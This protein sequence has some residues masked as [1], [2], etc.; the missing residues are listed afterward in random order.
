MTRSASPRFWLARIRP[1]VV[2]VTATA[3]VALAA[4]SSTV[5]ST[6]GGSA[7]SSAQASTPL[8]NAAA[9]QLDDAIGQAMTKVSIPGAIVGIWGPAGNY[10]RTFGVADKATRA[11]M[12]TDMYIRIGSVTKTFTITAL[13]QLVDQGKLAL[14]DPISKYM[15]G[16]PSG[17]QIT[18][19][20]LAQ[21]RSGLITFD[22]VAQFSDPYIADPHK[23]FTPA[24]LL[25]YALDKPLQFPPGTQY[26]YSNTN[27]VLLGLVVEKQSGQTLQ[28]Y[29]SEHI[30]A[31]LKLSHTSFSTTPAFP[32]PH[33][34]GYTT[35]HGAAQISTDWNFSWAWA[36]GNMI[37]TL[38]DMRIWARALATGALL[39]PETQRQRLDTS[40]PMSPKQTAFY[41]LGLINAAGWI[42]HAGVIFGYE[43]MAFY[44]PQTQTT[45]VFFINTDV[46]QEASAALAHAITSVI[47]PDHVIR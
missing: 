11:P 23:S 37:S 13:L 7:T 41:G 27:T 42:G 10:V 12:S 5:P 31:P 15:S 39:K 36:A 17:D 2:A 20:E 38:D 32:D 6:S 3:M 28:D 46:P 8:A 22:D 40:V 19:R 4:C 1:V 16:V 35:L 9:T 45:L 26:Q 34:Q 29:I 30:L 14:D 25:G 24:Q 47:C 43:T 44:L 21:M 18:L 33:P